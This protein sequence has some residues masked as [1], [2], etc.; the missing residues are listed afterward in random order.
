MLSRSNS[1]IQ[2]TKPRGQR[3]K[4]RRPR[5]QWGEPKDFDTQNKLSARIILCDPD[6]HGGEQALA[7]K[8]ARAFL[9]GA[10]ERRTGQMSLAEVA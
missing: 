5:S 1:R 9:Y 3:P 2:Q 6:A 4:A 7:V 8:W 10:E